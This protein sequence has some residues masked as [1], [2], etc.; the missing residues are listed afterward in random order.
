MT[1][2]DLDKAKAA[3]AE[4]TGERHTFT[5]Q[6]DTY[7]LP[8]ELPVEFLEATGAMARGNPPDIMAMARSLFADEPTWEKFRAGDPTAND[9]VELLNVVG[10]LYG[11]GSLGESLASGPRS[12]NGSSH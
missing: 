8:P 6:G 9:V 12:T 3:R 5:W 4:A 2:I 7:T 10:Q 11:F 1:T